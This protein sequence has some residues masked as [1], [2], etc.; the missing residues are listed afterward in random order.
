MGFGK[1]LLRYTPGS[2]GHSAKT[3]T[4]D[5]LKWKLER[6]NASKRE[7]LELVLTTRMATHKLIGKQFID[8][9]MKS[10]ILDC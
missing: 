7:L 9:T 1:F 3:M 4:K 8:P 5:F 2:V 6:P 10:E